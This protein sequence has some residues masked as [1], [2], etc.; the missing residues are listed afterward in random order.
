MK[1]GD[2]TNLTMK[3]GSITGWWCNNHLEKWWSSSR[4]MTSHRWW[5]IIKFMCFQFPPSRIY[6]H[7]KHGDIPSFFLYVYQA[8]S[9]DMISSSV[10]ILG[11]G[12]PNIIWYTEKTWT[13][14]NMGPPSDVCWFINHEITT[15]N[16]ATNRPLIGFTTMPYGQFHPVLMARVWFTEPLQN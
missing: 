6:T 16:S 3:H 5:K 9:Y 13:P 11:P 1:N 12:N 2:F 15:I 7:G 10:A 4:R 14:M 8:G